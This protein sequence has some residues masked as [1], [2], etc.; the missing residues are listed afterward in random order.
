MPVSSE[1][2]SLKELK[3][4][5]D[6]IR[7]TIAGERQVKFRRTKY[8]PQPNAADTSKENL[9]RYDAYITRAVFYNVVKRTL[10]GLIGQVF[11]REPII[12]IPTGLEPIRDDANGLGVDIVQLAKKA[13]GGAVGYGRMGLFVD[14]PATDGP[15]TRAQLETGQI[16]PSIVAYDPADCINWR[17]VKRGGIHVLS[18]VVLKEQ[19][20]VSDD[21]FLETLGTQY[22]VLRLVGDEYV[23]QIYKSNQPGG[24]PTQASETFQPQDSTGRPLKE[25]PFKFVGSENNDPTPDSPPMYDLSSLNIAHYRNS[26]DYEESCFIVGQP[27][28]YFTGLTENWVK[29]ILK[30]SIP[31]GARAAV[32][33]PVG[34]IAG[35][36]Q[37]QAN[38]L[39]KEAMDQKEKQMVALGAKLVEPGTVPRTAT[40]TVIDE[41]YE[42][43]IL[44]ASGDNV[45][46]AFDFALRQCA[47]FTG[48]EFTDKHKFELNTEFDLIKMSANERDALIKEWQAKAISFGELRKNLRRA[49][50]ATDDDETAISEIKRLADLLPA[51]PAVGTGEPAKPGN[52]APGPK[53]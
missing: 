40:E 34:S 52:Q 38:T 35:L 2:P 47:K 20:V 5:W 14:Y 17:F 12:E 15:A 13:T 4:L 11:S 45:S 32:P 19:Y 27:T 31:L 41:S 36:L 7:D 6:I 21:G 37:A 22:R 33:L 51:P 49:G 29:D 8:L 46:S 1:H 10:G 24:I 16:R 18:L 48:D 28:P 23:Q 44:S 25:I 3:I 43:S 53:Q 39:P 26:A 50:I 30:G 42:T 9:A